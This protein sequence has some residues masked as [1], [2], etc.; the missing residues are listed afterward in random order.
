MRKCPHCGHEIQ[1]EAVYCRFCRKS[2]DPPLWLTSL[3]KCAFCA[4]WIERGLE[5]CPLCGKSVAS[6]ADFSSPAPFTTPVSDGSARAILRS[7]RNRPPMEP[8]H[9]L[10]APPTDD[11]TSLPEDTG[12]VRPDHKPTD[13]TPPELGLSSFRSREIGKRKTDQPRI[14]GE[15]IPPKP[16]SPLEPISKRKLFN[17]KPL[18]AI[19]IIVLI[20][21]A[22]VYA[23]LVPGRPFLEAAF[24]GMSSP[25][26]ETTSTS[27]VETTPT[28]E[29]DPEATSIA[30][31]GVEPDC[32]RWDQVSLSDEGRRM[33]VYG[34]LRR[35]FEI[36]DYPF[37]ALFSESGGTFYIVDSARSHR[38]VQPGT[39]IMAEGTIEIMR[40]VRP[41]IDAGGTL[42]AC[43]ETP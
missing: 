24:S 1:D 42:Q 31:Q 39:C 3:E 11:S 32:V 15:L 7:A 4:E 5:V 2:V 23:A 21:A 19:G 36:E 28:P 16:A 9:P 20:I 38:E 18:A 25:E 34:V 35:W 14:D 12:N 37:V 8:I 41:F 33:C 26:R 22:A 40:G 17:I 10:A 43:P 29:P 6:R 27:V 30:A 13:Y